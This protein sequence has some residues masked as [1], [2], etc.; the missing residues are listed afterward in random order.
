MTSKDVSDGLHERLLAERDRIQGALRELR[1][2]DE[3][4][5][6]FLVDESDAIDQHPADEGSELFEREKNMALDR[7]LQATLDQV[8]EAL[9]RWDA[10]TYGTCARCGKPIPEGRL[11][12]LP[13]A[14]YDID[15]QA[16]IERQRAGRYRG[17]QHS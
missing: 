1:G 16:V 3:Q 13:E 5:P 10:G 8:H 11:Q 17:A 14:I 6:T 4:A 7:E 9:A 12:A 2:G 15:C